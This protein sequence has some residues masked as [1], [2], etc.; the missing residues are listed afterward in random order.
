MKQARLFIANRQYGH[1][2][3]RTFFAS[4]IDPSTMRSLFVAFS[5]A[6]FWFLV[7]VLIIQ[8]LDI[9]S[10]DIWL[11]QRADFT[12]APNNLDYPWDTSH[13]VYPPWAAV[14]LIPFSLIP[15]GIAVLLQMWIM[16]GALT[17][18]I[19]KYGGNTSTVWLATTSFIAFDVAIEP[20]IDWMAYLG[21]LVPPILAGPLLLTKPQIALGAYIG[22]TPR[23]QIQSLIGVIVVLLLSLAIWGAWIPDLMDAINHYTLR[24]DYN[25]AFNMAPAFLLPL[26]V[27]LLIGLLFALYSF[28][29]QK[30]LYGVFAWFFWVPYLPFYSMMLYFALLA[31]PL[32]QLAKIISI[33]MWAIFGGAI[34]IVVVASFF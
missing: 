2:Q 30:P 1:F 29:N 31:I 20:H 33:V 10:G 6:T 26:P 22:E 34:L 16:F 23:N 17:L 18:I 25:D 13:Y 12:Q 11:H 8:P 28:F 4:F 21:L 24:E 14:I 27:S 32:P 9:T 7:A 15:L 19:H 3:F 5:M